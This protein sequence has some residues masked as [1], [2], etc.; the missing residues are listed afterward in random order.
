MLSRGA[1]SLGCNY[2]EHCAKAEEAVNTKKGE[3][4]SPYHGGRGRGIIRSVIR[5][6]QA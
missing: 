3:S 1:A 5:R 6:K 2:R 4:A